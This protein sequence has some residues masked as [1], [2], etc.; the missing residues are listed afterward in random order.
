MPWV[1]AKVLDALL[2][3]AEHNRRVERHE[4]GMRE[5]AA[6]KPARIVIDSRVQR[7]IDAWDNQN[8]RRRE[9]ARALVLYHRLQSWDA[10]L[11]EMLPREEEDDG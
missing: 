5:P 9:E 2:A 4:A 3:A 6:P 7:L 8:A 11:E 10:V 1:P